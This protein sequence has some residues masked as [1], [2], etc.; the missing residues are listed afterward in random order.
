[1]ARRAHIALFTSGLSPRLLTRCT[2][3]IIRANRA[4][5]HPQFEGFPGS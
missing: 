3:N 2:A 5:D 1:M 4:Q